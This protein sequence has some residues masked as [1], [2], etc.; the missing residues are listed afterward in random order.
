MVRIYY[1]NKVNSTNEKA[2]GFEE[3]SVIIAN[4]QT[5][6]KGRFNRDWSSSRGGIYMSI[7]LGLEDIKMQYLTFIAAISVFKAIKD[8]GIKTIIKWPNDLIYDG[9]KVCGILTQCV[10]GKSIIGIGVNT[11][12]KIPKPLNK[13]G[14]H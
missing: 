8:Y 7:V 11:N 5:K 12:N 13:K 2:K 3:N 14:Y 1:F 9:K 6:G 10:G 4:E